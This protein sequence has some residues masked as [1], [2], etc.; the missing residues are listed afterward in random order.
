VPA[1]TDPD[2]GVKRYYR[3]EEDDDW[4]RAVDIFMAWAH[5]GDATLVHACIN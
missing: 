3:F 1:A 5:G 2:L 4:T